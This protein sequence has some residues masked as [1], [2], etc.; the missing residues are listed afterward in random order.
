MSTHGRPQSLTDSKKKTILALL[1]VG[2]SRTTAARYV[3]CDPKTIYNTA[4]RDREFADEL[5]RAETSAE[6]AYLARLFKAGDDPKYW[7]AAAWALERMHPDRF[8]VRSPDSITPGQFTILLG[9]LTE[10]L[11]EEIPVEMYRKKVLARLDRF[12][13]GDIE[14]LPA[15]QDTPQICLTP[16]GKNAP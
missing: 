1:T 15:P 6:Y 16:T 13:K 5:A 11:I 7:R 8:G 3:N 10:M 14:S 9:R 4:Q 2:C 12:L